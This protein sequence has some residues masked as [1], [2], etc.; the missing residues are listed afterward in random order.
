MLNKIYISILLLSG[1][2]NFSSQ[3]LVKNGSFELT[4][5]WKCVTNI[6]NPLNS[7]DP[8]GKPSFVTSFIQPENGYTSLLSKSLSSGTCALL[9]GA[10]TNTV[11]GHK[12]PRSGNNLVF[13]AYSSAFQLSTNLIKN[14]L[15]VFECYFS[16]SSKYK[17]NTPFSFYGGPPVP[18]WG[19]INPND[20]TTGWLVVDLLK[21]ASQMFQAKNDLVISNIK[22]IDTLGWTKVSACFTPQIDSVSFIAFHSNISAFIDDIAIYPA[23]NFNIELV[24]PLCDKNTEYKVVNPLP[25]YLYTYNFGDSS[26]LYN[27]SQP[28]LNHIYN[29]SGVYNG[30]LIGKDTISN[31]FFCSTTTS[32]IAYVEANFT[33]PLN[34]ASQVNTQLTNS[35]I[36]GQNY[37]WYLNDIFYTNQQHPQIKFNPIK[38]KL[39]LKT[40]SKEGCVDSLCKDIYVEECGKITNANI[41]TPNDDGVNDFYNFFDSKVCDST[42]IKIIV[43][44]RWGEEFYRYPVNELYRAYDTSKYAIKY[45]KF[46]TYKYWNGFYFNTSHQKAD[47]GVYFILIET[48]YE[49]K[50]KTITL[51]R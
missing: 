33:Y 24:S 7:N 42:T 17:L 21:N 49:H 31:Q 23:Q 40:T 34:V 13:G 32:T 8:F 20:S 3:N 16:G 45:T 44:N 39:C 28:F 43:Y 35:S 38:N 29:N 51:L 2:L 50:T 47:D 12:N 46:Y 41:F 27:T 6:Q 1:T 37:S 18:N 22:K 4:D 25:N 19:S 9:C 10:L 48:P 11:F 36:N 26:S 30:F 15:Y 5:F 14:N